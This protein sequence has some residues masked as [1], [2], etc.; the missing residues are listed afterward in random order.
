MLVRLQLWAEETGSGP[1]QGTRACLCRPW[2][3]LCVCRPPFAC[4]LQHPEPG[5][6]LVPAQTTAVASVPA[7]GELG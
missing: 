5:Y 3:G 2:R 6:S 4:S 7:L 1:R